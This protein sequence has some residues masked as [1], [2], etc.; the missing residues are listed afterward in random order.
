MILSRTMRPSDYDD[1]APELEELN[2]TIALCGPV[3]YTHRRWEYALIQRAVKTFFGDRKNLDVS[4]Y[5]CSDG[6]TPAMML[7][8]GHNVS[9]YE[10]WDARYGDKFPDAADKAKKASSV[11]GAGHRFVNKALGTLGPEDKAMYDIALCISVM[12]HIPDEVAAF[13]DILDSLHTATP[14]MAILTMDFFPTENDTLYY[15]WLRSRIYNEEKMCSLASRAAEKGFR[16]LNECDWSWA[17]D[18]IMVQNEYGFSSIV[19]VRD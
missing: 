2:K 3:P 12:E 16:L 18:R 10:I 1:F 13:N 7:L 5:G 11:S 14:C 19:V 8:A 4:D 15:H 17:P 9:L 6:L